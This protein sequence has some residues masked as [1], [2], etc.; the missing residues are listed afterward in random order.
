VQINDYRL[1]LL[2]AYQ[3]ALRSND[4]STK[5]GAL[6]VNEGWNVLS[7]CNHFLEGFGH[8]PEHHA[9]PFKYWVTEH[10]ERAVI[11]KAAS[12]GIKTSGLMLVANWVACPDCARAIV[13]SGITKV[14]CHKQ[15]QDKTPERWAEQIGLGVEIIKR[16][17][18][19]V[20]W[21][22]KIGEV[23]NLKGGKIWSP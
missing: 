5:N 7:D 6:L 8:L 10:A 12:K 19:F 3:A 4:R 21:D 22:G 15:C 13:I 20:E 1:K 2:A 11:L 14:I 18:D 23:K 9:R 16:H 17:C